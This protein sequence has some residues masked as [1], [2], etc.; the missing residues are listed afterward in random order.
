MT[1]DRGTVVS[2]FAVI[3]LTAEQLADEQYWHDLFRQHLDPQ[4]D[5]GD[6]EKGTEVE[7]E[8]PSLT[9]FLSIPTQH[10]KQKRPPSP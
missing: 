6:K 8:M 3:R 10:P 2:R 9:C 7:T 5:Y 1:T 4:T